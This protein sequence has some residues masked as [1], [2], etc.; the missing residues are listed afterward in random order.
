MYNKANLEEKKT[1][2]NNNKKYRRKRNKKMRKI[3][4]YGN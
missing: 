4:R 2:R 1:Q 3:R